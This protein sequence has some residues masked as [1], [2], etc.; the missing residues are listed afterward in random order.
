MMRW[1]YWVVTFSISSFIS[2]PFFFFWIFDLW[3]KPD[4]YLIF[5]L[6]LGKFYIVSQGGRWDDATESTLSRLKCMPPSIR[7]L[8]AIHLIFRVSVVKPLPAI[9]YI[10]SQS[11]LI[12]RW[13][14]ILQELWV[15]THTEHVYESQ[16]IQNRNLSNSIKNRGGGQPA[17]QP[18]LLPALP[19]P[20]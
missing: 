5:S 11:Q 13:H 1:T 9:M 3:T 17:P 18:E 20:G 8:P 7:G 14:C 16:C 10:L 12:C 15:E 4:L 6:V 2:V 19:L